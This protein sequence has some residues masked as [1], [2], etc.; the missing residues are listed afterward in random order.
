M[1]LAVF[2]APYNEKPAW[3]THAHHDLN[4]GVADAYGWSWPMTDDEVLTSLFALNQ[5]RMVKA[6]GQGSK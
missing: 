2:P 1:V 3:L 5:E 4:V 6:A